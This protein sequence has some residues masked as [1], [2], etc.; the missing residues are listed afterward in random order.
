[1]DQVT[2]RLPPFFRSDL[3]GLKPP[4]DVAFSKRSH[5][6]GPRSKRAFIGGLRRGLEGVYRHDIRR[7]VVTLM[8]EAACEC[9]LLPTNLDVRPRCSPHGRAEMGATAVAEV[10]EDFP[11]LSSVHC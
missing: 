11:A 4:H 5:L 10:V 3:A 2:P 6:E 8:D 9:N 7:T 1:V